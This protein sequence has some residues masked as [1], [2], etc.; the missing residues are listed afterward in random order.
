MDDRQPDDHALQGRDLRDPDSVDIPRLPASREAWRTSGHRFAAGLLSALIPGLGHLTVGHRRRAVLFFAPVAVALVLLVAW[1]AAVGPVAAVAYLADPEILAA[2]FA[3]QVIVLLWRLIAVGAVVIDRRFPRPSVRDAVPIA[4][5]ALFVILPQTGLGYLTAVARS[6]EEQAF[7][8]EQ[9]PEFPEESFPPDMSLPP[10]ASPSDGL[11]AT[12]IP[13]DAPK[14]TTILLLGVDSGPDRNT[15]LTDTMIV[16]SL[17]PVGKI[18]SMVSIPRDMVDVPLARGGVFHPKINGL[19]AWVRWH[20]ADFPGYKGNGP[21][22]LA[23]A[24]GKLLGIRIDYYAQVNLPG[25]VQVVDAVRGIDI[26]VDHAMCD[27]AYDEYGYK[28]SYYSIGAGHHHMN[29]EQALAY[30]RIR[31]SA[32]ESDFT[33]AGRQQQVLLALRDRIVQG[34]FLDDPVG[35]MRAM[36][37]AITTNVPPRLL[38]TLAPLMS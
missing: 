27:A 33:R 29:G 19:A 16:A 15:A 38:P 13:T 6:A 7:D 1:V 23:G 24:L 17:D 34:G 36:G 25:F 22:V 20:V 28:G 18:V 37:L 14:R 30:A 10:G 5:L 2:I 8:P 32:G 26:D 4:L 21:A 35:L 31:K 12:P 9:F 3:I 11:G